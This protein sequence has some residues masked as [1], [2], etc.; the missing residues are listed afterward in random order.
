MGPSSWRPSS[1]RPSSWRGA[2]LLVAWLVASCEAGGPPPEPWEFRVQMDLQPGIEVADLRIDGVLA[3][4][5]TGVLARRELTLADDLFREPRWVATVAP[6][7]VLPFVVA[8]DVVALDALGAV[9]LRDR[10]PRPPRSGVVEVRLLRSCLGVSCAGE[11]ACL[12]GRCVP[13]DC[14]RG[15]EASCPPPTCTEDSEC[16]PASTPCETFSRCEAGLCLTRIDHSLC[17]IRERCD[18]ALGCVSVPGFA[19]APGEACR[20]SF[21]CESGACEGGICC[22]R[23]CSACERCDA[24]TCVV[25]A[26]FSGPEPGPEVCD[27]LDD[28][29]D[30]R[31]DEGVETS[32]VDDCGAC[33]LRCASGESCNGKRCVVDA[34][35]ERYLGFPCAE[36]EVTTRAA[37]YRIPAGFAQSVAFDG[38][39]LAVGAPLDDLPFAGI[40]A[41]PLEAPAPGADRSAGA[42]FVFRVDGDDIRIEAALRLPSDVLEDRSF[43]YHFGRHVALSGA[44]LAVAGGLFPTV[45]LYVRDDAGTWSLDRTLPGREA[46]LSLAFS[47]TGDLVVLRLARVQVV[48][49]D[50]SLRLDLAVPAGPVTL[51]VDGE[52]L[53]V[54]TRN[55]LIAGTFATGLAPVEE[56]L[57]FPGAV[58]FAGDWLLGLEASSLLSF[59]EGAGG[60]VRERAIALPEGSTFAG[61]LAVTDD[62]IVLGAPNDRLTDAPGVG[63]DTRLRAGTGT[64]GAVYLY[65]RA[66]DG[67]PIDAP[68]YLRPLDDDAPRARFGE[69]VAVQDGTLFVTAPG[70]DSGVGLVRAFRLRP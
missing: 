27:G 30:G 29:C 45:Y 31:I 39:L 63:A 37:P 59:R 38:E 19:A 20:N 23:A 5:A 64:S 18:L 60:W 55:S 3:N 1:W 24:G 4:G 28:D 25:R 35:C 8:F 65:P 2:A 44:R 11:S 66:D 68:L 14:R 32:D 33:G 47:S 15:D 67:G 34:P 10:R 7:D 52:R 53:A 42:A 50:G 48:R 56:S 70:D 21:Q 62:W 36:L 57:R 51:A 61:P 41:A 58:T 13:L 26:G 54:R 46:V 6:G 17:P 9:V 16:A 43:T 69:A 12:G 22:D 40:D 49:P